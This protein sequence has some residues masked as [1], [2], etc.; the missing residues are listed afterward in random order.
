MSLKDIKNRLPFKTAGVA[1][2]LLLVAAFVGTC[3][4]FATFLL[5]DSRIVDNVKKS[6]DTFLDEGY[7]HYVINKTVITRLDNY[8]DA[9]MVNTASCSSLSLSLSL[10][11]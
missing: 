1:L 8:T 10:S 3:L 5:P 4:L 7:N 11:L 9:L 2:V 6:T